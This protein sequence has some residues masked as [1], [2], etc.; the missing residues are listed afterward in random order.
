MKLFDRN[1]KDQL[2]ELVLDCLLSNLDQNFQYKSGNIIVGEGENYKDYLFLSNVVVNSGYCYST[3]VL[4]R[5]INKVE[6]YLDDLRLL[7][8][9]DRLSNDST[10]SCDFLTL[11][12]DTKNFEKFDNVFRGFKFDASESGVQEFVKIQV[13]F[14]FEYYLPFITKISD[15]PNLNQFVNRNPDPTKKFNKLLGMEGGRFRKMIIARLANDSI[16]YDLYEAE[17]MKYE[18]Y[19]L[20]SKEGGMSSYLANYPNIVETLFKRLNG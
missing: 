11:E 1:S 4:N 6:N 7:F 19:K 13:A 3:I 8:V 20:I 15:V 16:F 12:Q 5:R 10:L 2:E 9:P 14:F 17:R 18:E